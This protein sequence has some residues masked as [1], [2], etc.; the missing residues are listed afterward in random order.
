MWRPQIACLGLSNRAIAYD[1]QGFGATPAAAVTTSDSSNLL[2]V[3]D[4]FADGRAGVVIGC[5]DGGRIAIDAALSAPDRI[6]ALVLVA[7][8]VSGAPPSGYPD[9]AKATVVALEAA[10]RAGDLDRVNELEA[11]LWLDGPLAAPGRVSGAARRLFIDMN[12]IAL[13]APKLGPSPQVAPAYPRLREIGIPTL[14]IWGTLEFP[15]IQA[16]CQHLL[17][18]IPGA[19]ARVMS[20]VAHLPSLE[21]PAALTRL[22]AGFINSLSAAEPSQR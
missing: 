14:I 20:G 2:A 9:E 12:A 19:R 18:E 1:R 15:D 17:H 21:Q 8:A 5:S 16:R 3:L 6:R 13:R 10:E 4:E 7:P 22:I 11:Q